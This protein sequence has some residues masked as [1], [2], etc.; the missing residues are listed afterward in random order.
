MLLKDL[1]EPLISFNLI[2]FKKFLFVM[3]YRIVEVLGI[4]FWAMSVSR[5][6]MSI[7]CV[8]FGI[9]EISELSE[10]SGLCIGQFQG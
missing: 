2:Y 8:C 3:E 1:R 9:V 6:K 4:K 7:S 10:F 5:G